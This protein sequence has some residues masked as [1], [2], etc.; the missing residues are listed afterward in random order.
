MKRKNIFLRAACL[1]L[2]AAI[3]FSFA[4]FIFASAASQVPPNL[5]SASND[6][7]LGIARAFS[8]GL[9]PHAYQSNYKTAATRAEFA[10]LATL[11]FEKITGKD[12][13]RMASFNDTENISIKKMGGMGI[14]YGAGGGGFDPG[15]FIPREQAAAMLSRLVSALGLPLLKLTPACADAD[16][17]SSWAYESVGQICRADVMRASGGN[18][19]PQDRLTREQA[20][21]AMLRLHDISLLPPPGADH[22]PVRLSRLLSLHDEAGGAASGTLLPQT[23]YAVDPGGGRWMQIHTLSGPKW[24]DTEFAPP[25]NE[26]AKIISGLGSG[27]AVYYQNLES[28]FSVRH[29][30]ER[31]FF[32]A[33]L[34]KAMFALMIF[35][36][37]ERGETD[38][39]RELIFT[40]ED[41][42]W[43]SFGRGA[44]IQPNCPVGSA[45]TLRRLLELMISNSDNV[46]TLI[47]VRTFGIDAYKSFVA[48]MG[49]S[50]GMVRDRVMNSQLTANEAALFLKS[51]YEYTEADNLYGAELRGYMQNNQIPFM[52]S[53]AK[54]P[55]ASKTGWTS[56]SAW[57][58]MAIVYANS[59]FILIIMSA[60]AGWTENDYAEYEK[61]LRNAQEFN[62]Y[63]FPG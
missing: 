17:I 51:I 13:L 30:T 19:A 34:S 3:L 54:Y 11:L 45:F 47:L 49:G 53:G 12:I 23:V 63:W 59:P 29:N 33:S 50:P 41:Q 61:I 38:L 56:P 37:A 46:A 62:D 4:P 21:L 39:N 2:A 8:L 22:E 40:S 32:G 26:S 16:Q 14:M 48:S 6:A 60:R 52:S 15:G 7:R 18:F 5:Y 24:I 35:E 58:D 9:I 57:H 10:A 28:G 1:F 43:G 25:Q 44:Y 36:M 31:Q 20:I 27:T 55:V 42:N